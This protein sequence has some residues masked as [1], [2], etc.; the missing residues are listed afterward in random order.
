MAEEQKTAGFKLSKLFWSGLIL[1]CAGTGPLLL[2]ILAAK[3]GLTADKNPN[4]IGPGILAFLT[5]LPSIGLMIWGLI[6]SAL[7]RRAAKAAA[8]PD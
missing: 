6:V 1:L 2:I 7:R 8:N 3:L 4:P 5:L